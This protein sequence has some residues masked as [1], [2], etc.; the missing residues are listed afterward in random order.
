MFECKKENVF[1]TRGIAIFIQ[2]A[3]IFTFLTIFFFSYVNNVD[4]IQFNAQL[5]IIVDD[6]IH[7]FKYQN[8]YPPGITQDTIIMILNGSL[9]LAKY[10]VYKTSKE[11]NTNIKEN[12]KKIFNKSIMILGIV[13]SLAI[14]GIIIVRS[15]GYCLPLISHIKEAIIAV[16]ATA[17]TEYFFLQII[18]TRYISADPN[19]VRKH[20]AESIKQYIKK[21][22]P[23]NVSSTLSL[24]EL[25]PT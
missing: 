12:N 13:I 24:D 3:L 2:I 21:R 10:K 17:I 22:D 9:D 11:V 7:D 20:L 1:I 14:L 23:S 5:N 6:I 15:I 16:I 19:D 25:T 8:I 18:T 4:K